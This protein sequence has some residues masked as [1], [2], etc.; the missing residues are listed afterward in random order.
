MRGAAAASRA[1]GWGRSYFALQAVAGL[2]WWISVFLSPTVRGA[3]LG[4]LNPVLVA[5]FDVPLFVIGSGVA[6]FGIR[7]AAVVATGWTVLVSILL[8]AYATITTEAGWGVLIMA[9]AAAC[10]VVALFLVVQG[11]VPTE[12]I[13]RGPF[14]FRPA[15]TLRR[16][17]ANVGAT[18]GQLVLF[19]GFFLVVLPSV[20]WWLEQRWLVSLPFPSA[21]APAGLVILVLASCL[22]VAS[23]VAMSSTGGGTPLPSAMPNRLVI[24]GPYRWVRNPMAVAGISQGAAVGLILGSWLVIAYA[25]IGSLL[26]NYAVRPHE[27]ADLERRFG[28]DF[29]RYRDSV[30][31]WIPHP[32]RTRPAAR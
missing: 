1:Q 22:G 27:E 8:A 5:A 2:A 30:R 31:C 15:P 7:A 23:A 20:I 10:S 3:T 28:A 17:A 16:T 11:R 4:S 32:R 18:M 6:A 19:W 24:A 12:L 9:A 29:R 25:V 13:V 14:A 21:A 26:W